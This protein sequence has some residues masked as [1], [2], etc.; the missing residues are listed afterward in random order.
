MRVA[1]LRRVITSCLSQQENEY[2]WERAWPAWSCFYSWPPFYS[3]LPWNLWSTQ[4][5]LT[6]LQLSMGLFLCRHLTSSASFLC[7]EGKTIC[8]LLWC[9]LQLALIWASF[10][11]FPF[12]PLPGSFFSGLSSPHHLILSRSRNIQIASIKGEFNS[13]PL[14]ANFLSFTAE[15]YVLFSILWHICIGHHICS[16]YIILRSSMQPMWNRARWLVYASAE[17]FLLSMF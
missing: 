16:T 17:P 2:V 7:E 9:C 12:H 6:P 1:I 4:R 15:M 10:T 11:S 3:T 5:T 13:S 14:K 8:L